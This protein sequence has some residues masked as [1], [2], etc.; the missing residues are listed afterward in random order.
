MN[1][2]VFLN[3]LERLKQWTTFM[4]TTFLFLKIYVLFTISELPSIKT[5]LHYGKIRA[6][7]AG[8]K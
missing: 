5:H 6:K 3:S 4:L 8:F 2:N 1:K 7:L